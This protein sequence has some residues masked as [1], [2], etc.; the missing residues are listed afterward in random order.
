MFLQYPPNTNAICGT[1]HSNL[2]R[3]S[4]NAY[5]YGLYSLHI[6]AH[7]FWSHS[8]SLPCFHQQPV[9]HR[10]SETC[11]SRKLQYSCLQ[12]GSCNFFHQQQVFCISPL[13][14]PLLCESGYSI[15]SV[16]TAIWKKSS[17]KV[18]QI[19]QSLQEQNMH[20]KIRP[21]NDL[22]TM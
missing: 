6:G 9:G 10:N 13:K 8:D 4:Q 3:T 20:A 5:S 12:V 2:V 11:E 22:V 15:C 19:F 21:I 16:Q 18:N 1:E 7:C 14:V 17:L